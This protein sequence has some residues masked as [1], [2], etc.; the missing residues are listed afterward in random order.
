MSSTAPRK[1]SRAESALFRPEKL[2]DFGDGDGDWIGISRKLSHFLG[3]EVVVGQGLIL[4]LAKGFFLRRK[5]DEE[6]KDIQW[7]RPV[8]LP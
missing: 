1:L 2:W 7:G 4:I 6:H 3:L 8:K 5:Y